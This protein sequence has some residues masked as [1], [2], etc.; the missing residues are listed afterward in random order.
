MGGNLTWCQNFNFPLC[1]AP[2]AKKVHSV[3]FSKMKQ[4]F[5][6]LYDLRL[7]KNKK[8]QAKY[9]SQVIFNYLKKTIFYNELARLP[10]LTPFTESLTDA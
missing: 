3:L 5:Y 10:S 9:A 7:C 2:S 6:I 4:S 8:S 1:E